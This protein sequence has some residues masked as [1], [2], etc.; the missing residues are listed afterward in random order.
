MKVDPDLGGVEKVESHLQDR[1]EECERDP[2]G[3]DQVDPVVRLRFLLC[4]SYCQ[5]EEF[6]SGVD[7]DR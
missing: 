1:E 2:E 4:G 7:F 6:V 5:F 3:Q